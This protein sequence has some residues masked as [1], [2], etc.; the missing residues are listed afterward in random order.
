MIN[1]LLCLTG[2]ICSLICVSFA[3]IITPVQIEVH[4]KE[5]E[6]VTLSCSYSSA[7][8]L[9]WYRQYP[10]SAPEFLLII[11]QA[12]GKVSQKS[13]IVDRDPRFFGKVNEEKTHVILE[14]SSAK[15]TDAALYYCALT[16]T[17]T[18]NTTTLYKN[19]PN[20]DTI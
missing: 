4:K 2:L 3:N 11:L 14:I 5:G 17:V 12:T 15:L 18:G 13:E 6:N 9:Q 1:M 8:T 19:P 7:S 20:S 16:P 10:G